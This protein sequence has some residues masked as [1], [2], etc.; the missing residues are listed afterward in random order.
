MIF[1]NIPSSIPEPT[2]ELIADANVPAAVAQFGLRFESMLKNPSPFL[3][4]SDR[5]DPIAG[6]LDVAPAANPPT[7]EP[8]A[9]P[10]LNRTVLR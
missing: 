7:R 2:K 4:K 3:A 1:S 6:K 5:L 9:S 10:T 8:T